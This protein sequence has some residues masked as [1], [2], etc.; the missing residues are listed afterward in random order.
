MIVAASAH[1][2]L[3][4]KL[5]SVR[6]RSCRP[7][8]F[9]RICAR[10]LKIFGVDRIPNADFK[11][12]LNAN[13]FLFCFG[14]AEIAQKL[15]NSPFFPSSRPLRPAVDQRHWTIAFFWLVA[16]PNLPSLRLLSWLQLARLG[17]LHSSAMCHSS[18]ASCAA[19]HRRL[20][21]ATCA[22]MRLDDRIYGRRAHCTA[23]FHAHKLKGFANDR[24]AQLIDEQKLV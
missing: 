5:L 1:R 17:L 22:P 10:R 3:F 18:A 16:V 9:E 6:L 11:F 4:A 21:A 12:L 19:A 14:A 7:A 8:E 13:L 15:C 20:A 24:R 23:D 2:R